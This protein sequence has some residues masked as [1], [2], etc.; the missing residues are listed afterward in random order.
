MSCVDLPF[1]HSGVGAGDVC[2]L[3]LTCVSCSKHQRK[4]IVIKIIVYRGGKAVS[5]VV[6]SVFY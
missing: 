5:G 2:A 3:F 1:L 6:P 4:R